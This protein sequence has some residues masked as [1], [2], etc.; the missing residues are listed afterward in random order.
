MCYNIVGDTMIRKAKWNDL[1]AIYSIL[2]ISIA[3]MR[4]ENNLEQWNN[5]EEIKSKIRED[6]KLNRYYVLE[7]TEI[8]ASFMY[9]VGIDETYNNIEGS[10]LND[11]E[12]GVI[13][14]IMS[15]F[16]EKNIIGQVLDYCVKI[17]NHI[18]IDTHYDNTRM[19]NALIRNG[20]IE[21]GIIYLKDGNPRIAYQRRA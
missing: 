15:N 14:R 16:K 12:Y 8:Y 5:I 13:H 3:K 19:R 9:E 17:C 4:S 6:I 10:W 7:N 2:E 20:F 11:E 1:D 18:R 21:C